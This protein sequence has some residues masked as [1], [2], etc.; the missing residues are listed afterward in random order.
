MNYILSQF[1]AMVGVKIKFTCCICITTTTT[2]YG[3][4]KNCTKFMLS[5]S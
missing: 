2:T 4:L 3:M 5:K 1:L